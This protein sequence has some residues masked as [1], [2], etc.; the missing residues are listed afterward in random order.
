MPTGARRRRGFDVGRLS[1]AVS[2]PGIDPRTWVSMARVDR[3]GDSVR[4]VGSYGWVVDVTF[5]GDGLDQEGVPCRV[6]NNGPTGD[7]FGEY[8]PP[9]PG[10]E[11]LVGV[12]DGSPENSVVLGTLRNSDGCLPPS[13]ING[14]PI[15]GDVETSTPLVGPVSPYDT[16]IKRSPHGRR[17]QYSGDLVTQAR[18]VTLVSEQ[19]RLGSETAK[20]PALLGTAT[21]ANLTTLLQGLQVMASTF[22]GMTGPL[23]PFQAVG[24]ALAAAV[25]NVQN[26]L[27][28]QLSQTVVLD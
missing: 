21:N 14:L 2:R 5:Y 23:A 15:S 9:A 19:I 10:V 12:P 4:W 8:V 22:S 11:V 13:E 1:M 6:L 25:T 18:A 7:G 16:E 17:E 28:E 3:D 24:T 26:A 20:Q 27:P